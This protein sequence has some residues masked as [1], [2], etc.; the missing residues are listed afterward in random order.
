MVDMTSGRDR[1][2]G[3]PT[4]MTAT[5]CDMAANRSTKVCGHGL[6]PSYIFDIGHPCYGQL[7]PIVK[8]R[9]LLTI[10]TCHI[11][12][13]SFELVYFLKLIADEKR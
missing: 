3:Y 12:G 10:M 8:P 6:E 5:S 2:R 1:T 4:T 13:S 7:T 11:A 9:Y